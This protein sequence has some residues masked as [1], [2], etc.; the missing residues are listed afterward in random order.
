[1]LIPTL[2]ELQFSSILHSAVANPTD[3][4]CNHVQRVIHY[5]YLF[6]L[7]GLI[8]L[9]RE[10]HILYCDCC[11]FSISLANNSPEVVH[12]TLRGGQ[13]VAGDQ[14]RSNII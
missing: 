4:K 7:Q 12:A 5:M 10:G 6:N 13:T 9:E 11:I 14:S 3:S 8:M 1:M 2:S